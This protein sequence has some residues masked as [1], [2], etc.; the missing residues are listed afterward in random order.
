M[1]TKEFLNSVCQEIKYKPVRKGIAEELEN[2]IQEIKENYITEGMQELE[3]EEKAVA[4]MGVAQDIGKKLNKVHRPKLDWKLLLITCI[5]IFF[6]GLVEIIRANNV[7]E[8]YDIKRDI[9]RYVFF[10]GLGI[11]P[12]IV[13]YFIDYKKIK[14]YSNVIYVIATLGIFFALF[15]GESINGRPYLYFNIFTIAPQV[16]ALPLYI[17]AFVGFINDFNRESKLKSIILKYTNKEININFNLLK[18]VIL[19]VFS[20]MLLAS[21]PSIASALI[22]VLTYLI[23]AT[24]K[25]IQSDKDKVKN[26][27]K[28]WGTMV[29]IGF[30]VLTILISG[31]DYRLDRLTVAFNP[32]SDPQGVGWAAVNREVII[33]NARMYGEAKDTSYAINVFDEGT[34][35]AF[36]SVIAHY[37]WV[38]GILIVTAIILFSFK[39]IFNAIKIKEIY[40]KFLIIG[41]AS[42]FIFQSIFN[43]FMNLNLLVESGFNL[44]FISYGIG[45]LVVNIISLGTILSVYKRKDVYMFEG[46]EVNTLER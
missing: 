31:S 6:G 4:Q 23:I 14:K 39:L 22:L 8:N 28:L 36:I 37:G 33:K 25:I 21:I 40:G 46:N 38:A 43:I 27:I 18:I 16:I 17:I 9:V 26:L 3:A 29:I 42:M 5:L 44:P 1:D 10:L 11:I 41:L 20:L 30:F 35:Y 45:N 15:F 24:I 32:E 2:H 19:S 7:L 34:D 12:S 13:I